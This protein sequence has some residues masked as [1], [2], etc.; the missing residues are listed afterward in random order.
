[1]KTE[2]IG[3]S[4]DNAVRIYQ[5][6]IERVA[7]AESPSVRQL[8]SDRNDAPSRQSSSKSSVI[9]RRLFGW[10]VRDRYEL[11]SEGAK[12]VD[13]IQQRHVEQVISHE[14]ETLTW[15]TRHT[16]V[17]GMACSGKAHPFKR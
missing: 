12:S 17:A 15:S 8:D 16:R 2:A 10:R 5:Q 14:F 3:S 9:L 7:L 13:C 1:M 11:Y 6:N 4:Q